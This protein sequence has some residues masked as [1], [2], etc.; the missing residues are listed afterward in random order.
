[1]LLVDKR[2]SRGASGTKK[3]S[4]RLLLGRD[5]PIF[6]SSISPIK[7]S[8]ITEFH[9]QLNPGCTN[10]R[11]HYNSHQFSHNFAQENPILSRRWEIHRKIRHPLLVAFSHSRSLLFW[12][13]MAPL[14]RCMCAGELKTRLTGLSVYSDSSKNFQLDRLYEFT[15]TLSPFYSISRKFYSVSH[16][17]LYWNF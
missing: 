8:K 6:S 13:L 15:H 17:R 7:A 9:T 3:K 2:G 12:K 1:M 5:D 4:P 16:T 11:L 10:L 14:L